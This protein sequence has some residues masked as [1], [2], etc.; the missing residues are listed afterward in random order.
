MAD[1]SSNRAGV[2]GFALALLLLGAGLHYGWALVPV[3]HMAQVWNAC[4]AFARAVLLLALVWHVRSW[5]VLAVV[6][7]WLS[8]E[9]QVAGCSVAFIFWPWHVEPGRAQCSSLLQLDLGLMGLVA[10][11]GLALAIAVK[12]YR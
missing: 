2:R 12:H 10:I 4:G 6:A 8:E 9:I 11:T 3:Q 7:W 1:R 5:L